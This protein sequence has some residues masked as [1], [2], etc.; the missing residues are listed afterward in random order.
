MSGTAKHTVDIL[1]EQGKQVGMVKIVA[2]RPFPA[3]LLKAALANAAT[4]G[5]I[6]R[7]ASFGAQVGPVATEVRSA[8]SGKPVQGFI[9][10]LGGRDVSVGTFEKAFVCLLEQKTTDELVWL[11][12]KDNALS[13]REVGSQC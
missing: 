13:L 11:D 5:V 7:S 10:G 4:V 3:A 9:A 8:L 12:V 6:D 1:R 2:F